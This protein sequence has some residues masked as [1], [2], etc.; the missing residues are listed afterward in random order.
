MTAP[1]LRP[2]GTLPQGA[3]K[4]RAIESMFDRVAGDY[5]RTNRAISLGLDARWRRKAVEALHAAAATTVLDLAC[6]TGDL[7]RKLTQTGY[8]AIGIDCSAGMLAAARTTAPLVR[9][10]AASLPLRDGT[11]GGIM[12]GFALR[13][14]VDLDV[15]FAECARVLKPG[16]R[17]AALDASVPEHPLLRVGHTLWFRGA[18]P[19]I[20][21]LLAGNADAYRYLPRSTEYLP[22]PSELLARLRDAGFVD[23]ER[24]TMTGGAVQLYLAT[25]A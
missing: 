17:L 18:V 1:A 3:E 6:G 25:R 5:E 24:R 14:F 15:V 7:C 22:S 13:N 10:D 11:V 12:C 8:G 9:G 21:R 23:V 4:R 2:D 16:G 20:G 19:V